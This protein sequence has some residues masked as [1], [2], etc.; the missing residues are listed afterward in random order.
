MTKIYSARWVVPVTAPPI[1]DGAVAVEGARIV[2][3][4]P[5]ADVRA[6]FPDATTEDFG[7]AALMPGLVNCHTHLELTAMRG[8][9]EAEEG[10]FFAW[11]RK[12]TLA[13]MLRLTADDLRVS[14]AWGAVEAVRAGVTCVGDAASSADACLAAL[15]DV[16]LRGTIY[17]EV[18]GPDARMAQEQW[19]QSRAQLE[20][21]RTDE[22]PLVRVGVSPHAP[23]TVSA[24]LLE[25]ITAYT[26]DQ[27]LPVMMHAAESEMETLLMRAGC[28]VFADDYAR[29]GIEWRAPCVSPIQYLAQ[30]G[31]LRARPLLVHCIRVD[32]A[33]IETIKIFDARVAHCPKSNAKLGHGH[34]P[35]HKFLKL[36]HGFGSDSVASNNTC[37]L[38]AEAST[39][40]LMARAHAPDALAELTAQ[41]ALFAATAGGA[42]ALG[43]DAQ[44]GALAAGLQAD[45]IA[46]R[47]D[48]AHQLP[49]YDP[50]SALIFA[51]SGR[52]VVLTVVAGREIYRD[53][54]AQTVDE[55]RL[56]ARVQEIGAKLMAN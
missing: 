54:R 3:V 21:L 40:L 24:P 4:G 47:L 6:Q 14:A 49:V 36:K 29:R 18:F 26:L 8:F 42:Q 50:L 5:R 56:R 15:A 35:Y 25:M 33:D 51:S 53:G 39:A 46:V 55:E 52:D 19:I 10:N 2:A 22:T 44:T 9:L 7:A 20:A 31:V 45:L 30:V 28:G 12:L 43:L 17:Q 27:R 32:D 1:A 11:L 34:A 41:Q 23:Y 37:D 48:G 13:R 16:G 38:L